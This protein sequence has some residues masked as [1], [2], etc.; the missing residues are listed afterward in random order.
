MSN[1]QSQTENSRLYGIISKAIYYLDEN[2]HRQP[3]LKDLSKHV[4]LSEYHLQ[5]V[6]SEWAGVSPKQYL[7]YL[8]KEHAKLQLATHSIT[9]SALSTGLSGSS[10][11]HDL[12]LKWEGM[13]PGEYKKSGQGLSIHY[14][15]HPSPF[16]LCLL[17]FT[18]SRLCHLAF[19]DSP[20]ALKKE[21]ERLKK[22]WALA[23]VVRD[24]KL[25]E[26]GVT[27]VFSRE[28]SANTNF[29]LLLK[30]TDFQYK[31][32]EALLHIPPGELRSYQQVAEQINAPTSVRA[33]ASAIAGNN[34]ACLIPCHR[35]IRSN[36]EFGQFR[37]G[38]IRKKA[39]IAREASQRFTQG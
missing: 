35:V 21:E 6:F 22:Q 31:V 13:T 24:D 30:G 32:W 2:K 26:H 7:Q 18:R 27:R 28:F 3:S 20:A 19:I 34:I 15:V 14:G 17:A 8:T 9:E 25:T 5:R 16:G 38:N 23:E 37:W 10:R 39:I 33:V 1:K 36:G 29:H 12:M 4:G 11:L